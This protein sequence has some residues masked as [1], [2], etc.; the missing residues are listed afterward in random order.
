MMLKVALCARLKIILNGAIA[1]S[2]PFFNQFSGYSEKAHC[3]PYLIFEKNESSIAN[4]TIQQLK[5]IIL[6][7]KFIYQLNLY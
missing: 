5:R 3:S 4:Q 1:V 2:S 7:Q 6:S